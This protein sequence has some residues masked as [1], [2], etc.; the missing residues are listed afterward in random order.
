MS[1]IGYDA[2]IPSPIG[3]C[4][5]GAIQTTASHYFQT[6][7]RADTPDYVKRVIGLPGDSVDIAMERCGSTGKNSTSHM[8]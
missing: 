3:M 8:P 5:C 4:R 1:R 2:G 6:A 7:L